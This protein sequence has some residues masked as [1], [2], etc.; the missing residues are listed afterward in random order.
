MA[1]GQV[2]KTGKFQDQDLINTWRHLI[3][4]NFDYERYY[5]RPIC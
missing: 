1:E 4:K 3:K 2:F 5:T